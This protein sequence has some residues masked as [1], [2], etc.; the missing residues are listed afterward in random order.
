MFLISTDYRD[1]LGSEAPRARKANGPKLWSLVDSATR[2]FS[3]MMIS[4]GLLLLGWGLGFQSAWVFAVLCGYPLA[5]S[6]SWATTRR[7]KR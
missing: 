3:Y 5:E 4:M 7:T 6:I 2:V 1:Y